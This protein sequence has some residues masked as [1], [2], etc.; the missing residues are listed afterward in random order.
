MNL[1]GSPAEV[2][3]WPEWPLAGFGFLLHFAWE[4]M[5][6]PWFEGMTEASHGA[7]VWLCTRAAL[8]DVVIALAAFW[9]ACL[10]AR[11]RQWIMQARRRP[12]LV[13]LLTGVV[14]TLAFEWLATGPLE[15]WQY[16]GEMPVVPVVGVGLTP[17]LQWLLL[18][19]LMVWLS[20]RHVL[21]S[22]ILA[23]RDTRGRYR[24]TGTRVS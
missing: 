19:P 24:H 9:V 17:L 22:M 13:M 2:G 23:A 6:V 21:G 10:V 18:P 20:R 8:G 16:A 14:V 3:R 7:V 12:L 5:Q 15:R 1:E 11:G 4:M